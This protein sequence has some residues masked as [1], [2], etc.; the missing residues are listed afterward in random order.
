M[1]RLE[2]KLSDIEDQQIL[3]QQALHLPS[4]KTSN[5]FAIK[6]Q[7]SENG[8]HEPQAATPAR[9]FGTD[10]MRRSN[11]G[12]QGKWFGTESMRRSMAEKQRVCTQDVVEIFFNQISFSVCHLSLLRTFSF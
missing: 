5:R 10:S 12:V 7:P 4:G 8:H 6:T 9:R 1:Q 11:A 3:R 2:E